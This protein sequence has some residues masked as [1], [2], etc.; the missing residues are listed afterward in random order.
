[1]GLLDK[2]NFW[3]KN[4]NQWESKKLSKLEHFSL[5]VTIVEKLDEQIAKNK[6]KLPQGEVPL[7]FD[8]LNEKRPKILDFILNLNEQLSIS[9]N[10]LISA[11]IYMNNY[12]IENKADYLREQNANNLFLVSYLIANKTL[13]DDH[14]P[15]AMIAH[16][17]G[18]NKKELNKLEM[19]FARDMDF[20]FFITAAEFK[21]YEKIFAPLF[22]DASESSVD[23]VVNVKPA[24]V[25]LPEEDYSVSEFPSTENSKSSESDDSE[26]NEIPRKKLGN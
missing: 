3:K 24:S 6:K 17:A 12:F 2:L 18:I 14:H 8:S 10:E 11:F 9:K 1:M 21:K 13:Q 22:D 26:I 4:E 19:D 23:A 5:I 15:Q 16:A 20:K 25:T 7:T